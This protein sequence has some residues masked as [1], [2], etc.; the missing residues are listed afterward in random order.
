MPGNTTA[1]GPDSRAKGASAGAKRGAKD[2]LDE[3]FKLVV[4]YTKQETLD[5]VL[6]QLKAL[7]R[8]IA[9]AVLLALGTVLL[10]IGFLR[11]LQTELG[12]ARG[13]GVVS[14]TRLPNGV[15]LTFVGSSPYS[16]GAH[17]TGDLSWVPYMGGALFCL[18]VAGFCVMRIVKGAR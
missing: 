12:G 18:A 16:P 13:S 14:G 5:P 3:L 10:S 11:A 2:G 15:T 8:G 6:R 7:G 4:A 9:G 17:L 1:N